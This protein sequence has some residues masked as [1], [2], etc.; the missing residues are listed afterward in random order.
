M[1]T[2][3]VKGL[4]HQIHKLAHPSRHMLSG[5]NWGSGHDP[6]SSECS[7]STS[8]GGKFVMY[9]Y[10]VSGMNRNNKV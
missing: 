5:H 8:S 1:A 7:P 2:V 6:D 10:S 4:K 9:A 3:G